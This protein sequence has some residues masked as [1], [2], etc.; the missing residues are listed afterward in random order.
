MSLTEKRITKL[1]APGRYGDGGRS[2]LYLQVLPPSNRSWILRFARN[3]RERWMR[4]GPL[5]TVSSNA[6]G[7][8]VSE[9]V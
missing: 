4:L 3:G 1:T 6:A 7:R 2:G 5:R 9:R 8:I